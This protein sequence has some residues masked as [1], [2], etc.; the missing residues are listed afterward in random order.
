MKWKKCLDSEVSKF[1]W[2][3]FIRAEVERKY[4]DSL[5][6][7]SKN[8]SFYEVKLM[9]LKSEKQEN[10]RS[11]EAFKKKNKKVKRK[12][13]ISTIWLDMKKHTKIIKF[14]KIMKDKMLMFVKTS[15]QRFVYDIIEA[16]YCMDKV[17]QTIYEK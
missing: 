3:D 2:S 6:K 12:C 13:T 10:L 14:K 15:H 5:M 11:V 1:V 7:I 16:F 4:K 9:A 8:D 17:V